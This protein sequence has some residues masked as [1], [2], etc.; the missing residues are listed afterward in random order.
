[1]TLTKLSNI[2][3]LSTRKLFEESKRLDVYFVHPSKL[4]AYD[5]LEKVARQKKLQVAHA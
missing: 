4:D 2:S 3:V 1:V 5:R